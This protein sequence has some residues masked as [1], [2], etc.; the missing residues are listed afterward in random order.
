MY[1]RYGA[2]EIQN[3]AVGEYNA[4][5]PG[6]NSMYSGQLH[7]NKDYGYQGQNPEPLVRSNVTANDGIWQK[8]PDSPDRQRTVY[9]GPDSRG[10]QLYSGGYL[11]QKTLGSRAVNFSDEDSDRSF[12]S[13]DTMILMTSEEARRNQ[14][15]VSENA[16]QYEQIQSLR[17]PEGSVSGSPKTV[18][19]QN[20]ALLRRPSYRNAIGEPPAEQ[21]AY[22]RVPRASSEPRESESIQNSQPSSFWSLDRRRQMRQTV[23]NEDSSYH[24]KNASNMEH[25]NSTEAYRDNRTE[26]GTVREP[27]GHSST[28]NGLMP[29]SELGTNHETVSPKPFV[30]DI[31]HPDKGQSSQSSFRDN[32]APTPVQPDSGEPSRPTVRVPEIREPG[33]TR[34]PGDTERDIDDGYESPDA[35]SSDTSSSSSYQSAPQAQPETSQVSPSL[36][37]SPPRDP[38]SDHTGD[39]HTGTSPSQGSS[40]AE[41]NDTPREK[42]KKKRVRFTSDTKDG[43]GSCTSI[44]YAT[45]PVRS[46]TSAVPD[47]LPPPKPPPPGPKPSQLGLVGGKVANFRGMNDMLRRASDGERPKNAA[48]NQELSLEQ[49]LK[50]LALDD[51]D[52][53]LEKSKDSQHQPLNTIDRQQSGDT[54]VYSRI[55]ATEPSGGW[56]SDVSQGTGE[57]HVP[58]VRPSTDYSETRPQE[59]AA[60]M[61]YPKYAQQ[62]SST[63]SEEMNCSSHAN[64]PKVSRTAG[65]YGEGLPTGGSQTGGLRFETGRAAGSYEARNSRYN[66]ATGSTSVVQPQPKLSL[67]GVGND[68]PTSSYREVTPGGNFSGD[69]PNAGD[70]NTTKGRPSPYAASGIGVRVLPPQSLQD[71]SRKVDDSAEDSDTN[72]LTSSSEQ[73]GPSDYS[74]RTYGPAIVL[75]ATGPKKAEK[76]RSAMEALF[77]GK[78]Q[79]S[80]T[81]TTDA[82]PKASV[83]VEPEERYSP[84]QPVPKPRPRFQQSANTDP[85]QQDQPGSREAEQWP[86]LDAA[87]N[88]Q[89][90]QS[91]DSMGYGGYPPN[92]YGNIAQNNPFYQD[93]SANGT[94]PN[95]MNSS[96]HQPSAGFSA[97]GFSDSP[98]EPELGEK[99]KI[100]ILERVLLEPIPLQEYQRRSRAFP[101]DMD[102]SGGG[103]RPWNSSGT[104][105]SGYG[106]H[107]QNN[108]S[109]DVSQESNSFQDR[110][111]RPGYGLPPVLEHKVYTDAPGQ[112]DQQNSET[113]NE[114]EQGIDEGKTNSLFRR[115]DKTRK[116]KIKTK[117]KEKEKDKANKDK[118]KEKDKT[119]E[120][121]KEKDKIK[122]KDKSKD[123]EKSKKHKEKK[124]KKG[125]DKGS[126]GEQKAE[127][128]S[129]DPVT[130]NYVVPLQ[131]ATED[132]LEEGD[133]ID[134]SKTQSILGRLSELRQSERK[135]PRRH[136]A[137]AQ[138]GNVRDDVDYAS[139][140]NDGRFPNTASPVV[141]PVNR[142][143]HPPAEVTN[144]LR[145]KN[146]LYYR[147]GGSGERNSATL[148]RNPNLHQSSDGGVQ[149]RRTSP[150]SSGLRPQSDI[151]L[152]HT[153]PSGSF[154][155]RSYDDSSLQR[156]PNGWDPADNSRA[157]G[158]SASQSVQALSPPSAST[159]LSP[160]GS[161]LE[162]NSSGGSY[163]YSSA[164]S[165]V[166]HYNGASEMNRMNY[167]NSGLN[168]SGEIPQASVG[169]SLH[170]DSPSRY[171]DRLD[172]SRGV[173]QQQ[174]YPYPSQTANPANG[175][176]PNATGELSYN[177]PQ[178][179][180]NATPDRLNAPETYNSPPYGQF[181]PEQSNNSIA[182]EH[183]EA[184]SQRSGQ[185][186][187]QGDPSGT[188]K[189]ASTADL[190]KLMQ[191]QRRNP[192]GPTEF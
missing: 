1:N 105:D 22:P 39:T 49:R 145:S 34:A 176:T 85:Y 30:N 77:P 86:R 100:V 139:R 171:T 59:G 51:Q 9:S 121:D 25:E 72:T 133:Y 131:D 128:T 147:M 164:S 7:P 29:S 192:F 46:Q 24:G 63:P 92:G 150:R 32:S 160:L 70:N 144:V 8:H 23:S 156:L 191:Q 5:P 81:P 104:M 88:T 56:G 20:D 82:P 89:G 108:N 60:F 48:T 38:A 37:A 76:P 40:T 93:A 45:V 3:V 138:M 157:G 66:P 57:K 53:I 187:D 27:A 2:P 119:K 42:K 165:H 185:Y 158:L 14:E 173:Q 28:V 13:Q 142:P 18:R 115:K 126:T 54:D 116:S 111:R 26:F 112:T 11:P 148:E 62:G 188:P 117:A 15:R 178:P 137:R 174:G 73:T 181:Y 79:K 97:V 161:S 44:I 134:T 64:D 90:P 180:L 94:D 170:G 74:K 75:G 130:V 152:D 31:T 183:A 167:D 6:I 98:T 149:L 16:R 186:S 109:V 84:K 47:P 21:E 177:S 102:L 96:Q 169:Q 172:S 95:S 120:K 83:G 153:S 124:D 35:L 127:T 146:D 155:A 110:D 129:P 189:F 80:P 175:G 103:S 33:T 154:Q 71:M 61:D 179:S 52:A 132:Q 141:A 67:N 68:T 182:S 151:Y 190:Y 106:S 113:T 125:K 140:S 123:K 163:M 65:D 36:R 99:P 184:D 166:E 55:H 19:T 162:M 107:P 87:P 10:Y 168:H 69:P 4:Q 118:D 114:K 12:S 78:T 135:F 43:D 122:E 101:H 50:M 143:N 58:Y 91:S 136:A 41:A 17:E 159:S